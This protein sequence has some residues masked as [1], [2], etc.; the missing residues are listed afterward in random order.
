MKT[1]IEKQKDLYICFVEY[2]NAFDTVSHKQMIGRLSTLG[3]DQ[4]DLRLLT[5]LYWE[6][7]AVVK[8]EKDRSGWIEIRR[9]VSQGCLISSDLFSLYSQTIITEPDEREGISS[10]GKNINK[11]R[12]ADYTVLIADTKSKLQSLVGNLN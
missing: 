3:V 10:G 2:E 8:V 6:Q 4:A 1:A 5:N 12:Y 11:T 9:G 7:S